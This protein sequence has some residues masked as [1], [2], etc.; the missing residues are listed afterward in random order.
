LP[1]G[2]V[3]ARSFVGIRTAELLTTG[4]VEVRRFLGGESNPQTLFAA[5]YHEHILVPSLQQILGMKC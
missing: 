3:R 4:G 1:I 2:D 5:S